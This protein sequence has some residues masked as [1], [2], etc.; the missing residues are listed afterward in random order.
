MFSK[1][2]GDKM[3]KL[4]TVFSGIGA[5]EHALDRLGWNH[6]VVFACDNG[7]IEIDIDPVEELNQI[8][9]LENID[10]KKEYVRSLYKNSSRKT[11]FVEKSYLANYKVKDDNFFYDTV[12]HM[13]NEG[14][15]IRANILKQDL[16]RKF[17]G[18]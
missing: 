17:N 12:Y 5:I 7:N 4:A 16:E 10:A 1:R 18:S 11:N 14:R 15:N 6:E 13:N 9:K 2:N 3:I 8:R